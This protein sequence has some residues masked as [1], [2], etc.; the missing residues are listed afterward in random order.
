MKLFCMLPLTLK[1]VLK[2]AYIMC[3]YAEFSC[4][5]HG[6]DYWRQF[7][8]QQREKKRKIGSDAAFETVLCV[9]KY[10]Q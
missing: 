10:Q 1:I 4:V 5:K 7:D 6:V 3:I 2:A 9:G 8:K